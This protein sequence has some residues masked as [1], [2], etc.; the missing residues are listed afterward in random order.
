MCILQN[1]PWYYAT[2]VLYEGG[3]EQVS[4]YLYMNLMFAITLGYLYGVGEVFY[5][6]KCVFMFIYY[7]ADINKYKY[8]FV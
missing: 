5:R 4:M 1:F 6:Y 2:G 7:F 8:V 3:L